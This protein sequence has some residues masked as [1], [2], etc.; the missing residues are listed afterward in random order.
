MPFHIVHKVLKARILKWF[1]IP[2]SSGPHFVRTLHHD[3]SVW[4]GPTQHGPSID[5]VRQ[6]CDPCDQ[7]GYLSVIVVFIL[8][9]L[10]WMKIRGLWKLPDGKDW[11]WENLGLALVGRA[12]L[13][14][15]LIQFSVD[16]WGCV[17]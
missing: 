9:A 12:M 1:A 13:S 3:P 10:W 14:N 4:G 17:P 15:S 7:F 16:G 8:S 6:G 5:R 2:F 11:L